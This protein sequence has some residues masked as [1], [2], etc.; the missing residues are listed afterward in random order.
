[1]GIST[2]LPLYVYKEDCQ[3]VCL[4]VNPTNLQFYSDIDEIFLTIKIRGISLPT[5]EFET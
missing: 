2:H 4:F 1:M 5:Y 3:F